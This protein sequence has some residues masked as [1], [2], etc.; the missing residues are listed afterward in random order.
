MCPWLGQVSGRSEGETEDSAAG[1]RAI[2]GLSGEQ[3]LAGLGMV[4]K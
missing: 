2:P 1:V 4:R 3:L